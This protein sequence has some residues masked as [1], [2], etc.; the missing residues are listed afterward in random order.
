M[1][2]DLVLKK[3]SKRIKDN[4]PYI[5]KAFS[6]TRRDD[7]GVGITLAGEQVVFP[8]DTFGSYFYLRPDGQISFDKGGRQVYTMTAVFYLEEFDSTKVLDDVMQTLRRACSDFGAIK[9]KMANFDYYSIIRAEV[10]KDYVDRALSRFNNKNQLLLV[11]F[12]VTL[13]KV[14]RSED[15]IVEPCKDC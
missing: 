2:I 1:S 15:C 13:P 9:F 5:N 8:A 11:Q 7:N 10:N 14:F 3:L 12:N 6:F 4:L